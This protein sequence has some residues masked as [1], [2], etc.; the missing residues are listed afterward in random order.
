VPIEL[1]IP[2]RRPMSLAHLLLDVNGTLS[3]RGS[4]MGAVKERLRRLTEDLAIHL[5]T[6]DTFGTGHQ[7][8]RL[9]GTELTRVTDGQQKR[10]YAERLGA[11][12]CAAVGNGA[13]DILMFE[14]CALAIAVLGPEGSSAR[15]LVAA[16]LVCRTID[17]ALDLLLTPEAMVA[18]LR[19]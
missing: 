1:E 11:Q 2:G 8:A 19:R 10:R 7:I 14:R 6:A 3:D 9:L 15:A 13:N 5:L 18:T 12:R 16:D 4:L 17:E